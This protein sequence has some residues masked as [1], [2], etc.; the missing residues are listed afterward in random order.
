MVR[1]MRAHAL[2]AAVLVPRAAMAQDFPP[3]NQPPQGPGAEQP[4]APGAEEPTQHP[5]EERVRPRWDMSALIGGGIGL[6]L[7]VRAGYSFE[8]GIYIGGSLLHFSGPSVDT[9]VGNDNESQM[10]LGADLGYEF[11]PEP[12]VELR[13]FIFTG[14]GM[15]N[16]MNESNNIVDPS[17][18]LTFAPAFLAAYHFGKLFVSAETRLQMTPSPVRFALLGGIGVTP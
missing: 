13:P 6:G 1:K 7:G 3:I 10:I 14:F 9:L 15:F 11:F 17:L 4:R 5:A 16:R 8:P 2:A 18:D 12:D